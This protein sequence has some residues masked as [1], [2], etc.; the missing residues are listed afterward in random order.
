MPPVELLQMIGNTPL[1][2]LKRLSPRRGVSVYAKLEGQDPS[3]SIKDRVVLGMIRA[4]EHRGD[5][6]P[7]MTIVEASSGNTAIA[8]A[9][10]GKQM[11]YSASVVVPKDAAPN[12]GDIL[13]AYGAEVVWCES[14]GGMKGAIEQAREMGARAGCYYLGQFVDQV[15][16]QTHYECTGK[17]IAEALDRIDVFVAGIGTSGTIM[18]VGRRLREKFPQVRIIGVEPQ[19]GERLQ[20]LRNISEGYMP[21]LLDMDML[22]GRFLLDSASAIRATHRIIQSEGILAGVS[23]GATVHVAMRLAE[24]M[25]EGNIVVMFSDGAWKYLPARPWDAAA[26]GDEQLDETYWW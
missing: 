21:S 3:G 25:D 8:L 6:R 2:R 1:V 23:A 9:M 7:G 16:I 15:N 14:R 20:G 5:L 11:G 13:N 17:E 19:M 12:I 24:K 22:S 4:A 26:R 18:G 10:I